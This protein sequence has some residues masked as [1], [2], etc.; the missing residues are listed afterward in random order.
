MPT[1]ALL[2]KVPS[3]GPSRLLTARA[4]GQPTAL[5]GAATAALTVGDVI[6]PAGYGAPPCDRSL[7]LASPFT[8]RVVAAR[9]ASCVSLRPLAALLDSSKDC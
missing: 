1:R 5:V 7:L 8:R 2:L 6:A 4:L 3:L 9:V